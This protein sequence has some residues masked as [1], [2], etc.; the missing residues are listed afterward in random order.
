MSKCV[1]CGRPLNEHIHLG[2]DMVTTLLSGPRFLCPL[3]LYTPSE[4]EP[5]DENTE[6]ARIFLSKILGDK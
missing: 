6:K 2:E 5:K 3:A 1:N 4:P